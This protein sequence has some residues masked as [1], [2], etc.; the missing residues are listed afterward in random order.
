MAE[1]A[2]GWLR[3][4]G[5]AQ[6]WPMCIFRALPTD[7]G[8]GGWIYSGLQNGMNFSISPCLLPSTGKA[9]GPER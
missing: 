5:S 8:E 3:V 2:Q 9:G 6:A 7:S 4:P 1:G